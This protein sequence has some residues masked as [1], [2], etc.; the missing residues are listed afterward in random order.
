MMRY[1][2]A[3]NAPRGECIYQGENDPPCDSKCRYHD[4]YPTKPCS[5]LPEHLHIICE[6]E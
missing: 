2:C 6:A 5:M 4:D 1:A 3:Y